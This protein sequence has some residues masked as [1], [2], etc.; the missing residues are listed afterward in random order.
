[1]G[2]FM[3]DGHNAL[4][5]RAK[6]TIRRLLPSRASA[7]IR[8]NV[9]HRKPVLHSLEMHVTDHCNLNCKGCGHFSCVSPELFADPERFDRDMRRLAELFDGIEIISLLGGEPLLHPDVLAFPASARAAFPGAQVHLVTNGLLVPRMPDSFWEELARLDVRLNISDYPIKRDDETIRAKAERFGVDL[10][11]S[12]ARSEFYAI[13]LDETGACD[14][15]TSFSK[16][17]ELANCPFLQDGR[18]YPCA[19][20]PLAHIMEERFDMRLPVEPA[21]SV[22]IYGGIDGIGIMEFLARAIPFCRFCDMERLRYFEW[23]RTSRDVGEW[24]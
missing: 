4:V 14:R 1:M 17:R 23:D 12:E 18:I 16:C 24:T 8:R 11:Y 22:D 10:W 19:Y 5:G 15:R 20:A 7:A 21:D 2:Y 13:P 6:A 3:H 9:L